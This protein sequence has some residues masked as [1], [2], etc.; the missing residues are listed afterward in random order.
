MNIRQ[1]AVY[2][3]YVTKYPKLIQYKAQVYCGNNEICIGS[4][5]MY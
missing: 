5:D 4:I 3:L 2:Q 1:I